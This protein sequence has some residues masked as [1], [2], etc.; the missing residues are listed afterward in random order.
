MTWVNAAV[1]FHHTVVFRDF[2]LTKNLSYINYLPTT[3]TRTRMIL[4]HFIVF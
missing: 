1:T 2:F 3:F 4:S